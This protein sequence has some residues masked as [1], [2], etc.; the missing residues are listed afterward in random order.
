MLS[1]KGFSDTM[2][3]LKDKQA[4]VDMFI[5]EKDTLRRLKLVS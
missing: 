5:R 2:T 1:L 3:T 4:E